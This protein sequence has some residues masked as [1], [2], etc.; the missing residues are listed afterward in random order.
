[1]SDLSNQLPMSVFESIKQ[2]DENGEYWTARQLANILDYVD[3]RN[4]LVVMRKAYAACQNSGQKVET[5]R[6]LHKMVQ[7]GSG[8][9]KE[10]EDIRLSRYACLLIVQ[11]ADPDKDVVA[12]G[13]TYLPFRRVCKNSAV[14]RIQRFANRRSKRIF[15]RKGTCGT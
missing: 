6:C 13:Q 14:R 12:L 9:T 7:I 15:L 11:N 1:M 2:V 4:F 3:Y 10:I 8:A 5:F